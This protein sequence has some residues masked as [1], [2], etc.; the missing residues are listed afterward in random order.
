MILCPI[1]GEY[2]IYTHKC[3]MS[4]FYAVY[5]TNEI[6]IIHQVT[7]IIVDLICRVWLDMCI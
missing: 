2:I 3:H 5:L 4:I 1:D 6:V 7:A